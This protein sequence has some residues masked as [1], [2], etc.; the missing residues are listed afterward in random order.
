MIQTDLIDWPWVG[1][2]ALMLLSL[3]VLP[4]ILGILV[5]LALETSPVVTLFMM[6]MGL[7]TGIFTIYRQVAEKYAR[8]DAESK[9][10]PRVGGDSC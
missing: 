9:R 2:L 5:D 3:S 1:R 10:I 7:N 4:V 6:L 8:L